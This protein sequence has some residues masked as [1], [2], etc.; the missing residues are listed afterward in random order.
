MQSKKKDFHAI[1]VQ[2]TSRSCNSITHSLAKL[3]L[4]RNESI[5]WVG[6]YPPEIMYLLNS[7]VE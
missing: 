2:H 4:E 3:V 6:P 7:L 5:V 1:K